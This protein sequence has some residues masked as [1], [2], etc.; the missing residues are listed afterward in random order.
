[1]VNQ[2]LS[3]YDNSNNTE[4]DNSL[5]NNQNNLNIPD[6]EKNLADLTLGQYFSNMKKEINGVVTDIS[7][8][9]NIPQTLFKNHRLFYIG[10]LLVVIFI[11]YL[12]IVNLAR[13]S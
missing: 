4:S 5:I 13:C 9:Q 12:F 1:M 7:N 8:K 2:N 3:K 10:I 11:V 6:T